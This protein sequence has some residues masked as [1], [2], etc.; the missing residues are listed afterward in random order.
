MH[1]F[2]IFSLII[3]EQLYE[4]LKQLRIYATYLKIHTNL[5]ALSNKLSLIM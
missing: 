3:N 2:A 4:K 1:K 5:R